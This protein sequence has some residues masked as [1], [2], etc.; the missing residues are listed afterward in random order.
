[1]L[2]QGGC[3]IMLY[4]RIYLAV[5]LIILAST[6]VGS[7][8]FMQSVVGVYIEYPHTPGVATAPQ[9]FGSGVILS[10]DGYIVTNHHV[11]QQALNIVVQTQQGFR[12]NAT[13]VGS[14]P[15]FDLSVIKIDG[16]PNQ[17]FKPIKM[18]TSSHVSAGDQVTA[19]GN[20]F[21]FDQTLTQGVVS[22][23]DREV[24]LSHRVKSYIQID[25]AVNPGNSGG[26]LV[27]KEGELVGIVSGIYGP[28][29]NI[30]IAFA[31]PMDIADPVI[32]Q[33]ISK[34]HAST[35]WVGMSTQPLTPELKDALNIQNFNG[36]LVSEVMTGSPAHRANLTAKD[37]ILEVNDIKVNSP[38][39]FASLVTAH[40]S[41]SLLTMNYLRE[42][43]TYS[44]RIKT[45]QPNMHAQNPLGKWGLNLSE[46]IHMRLDG[47]HDSG[48]E[49][50]QV[51]FQSSAALSG[52]Q[53]GDIIKSVN[54][55]PIKN[56]DDILKSKIGNQ[57]KTHLLEIERHQQR[58]FVPIR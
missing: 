30:G 40:G 54:E 37:V 58:F 20:A 6:S 15:E 26:A 52:L 44:T 42:N 17:P 29:F 41:Q 27:N 33:L 28:R 23:I 57:R 1:M 22:H 14:A 24:G 56:L 7:Q 5:T 4:R 47:I 48:V 53:P 16:L 13:V 51:A 21:G 46:Y 32:K 35:G 43:K 50:N 36:V 2:I 3:R 11:I 12:A 38:Q 8:D 19:I 31:I 25:A 45:D 18:G 39:H 49:I 55:R 10:E 9:A 34:G